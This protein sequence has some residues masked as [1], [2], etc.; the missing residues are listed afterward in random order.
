MLKLERLD[1]SGFKSFVDPVS[2]RFSGGITGIVGPNGCGK[3][4]LSDAISWVMGEQSAKSMRGDTME[5]VIF[6]GAEKRRPLGMGEVTLTF[7]APSGTSGVEDGRIILSRRVF[8]S[9]ESQYRLNGKLTRLKDVRDLLMDTGLGVRAYSVIEQGKIGMI[10]SGKPQER[11]RLLEEAAGITRYKERKRIA[12]IKIEEAAANLLRLDDILSEIERNLRSLKRQAG[13]A[14]R[15]RERQ[16]ELRDLERTVFRGRWASLAVALA[17][18]RDELAGTRAR[19]SELSATVHRAAAA[20]ARDREEIE[21]QAEALAV[22]VRRQAELAATIEGRQQLLVGARR[23]ST[24]IALRLDAGERQAQRLDEQLA[25]HQQSSAETAELSAR[26]V[27]DHQRAESAVAATAAELA[28]AEEQ[29]ERAESALEVLRRE[30]L[31]SLGQLDEL[32]LR[33]HREEIEG[34][35]GSFRERHLVDEL[36]AHA[37]ELVEN[38]RELAFAEGRLAELAELQALQ[39]VELAAAR[40]R[41]EALT[42]SETAAGEL[43]RQLESEWTTRSERRRLLADLA[44]SEADR[45]SAFAEQAAA[46]G[47]AN[48]PRLR[49]SVRAERGWEESL[50]P[51]VAPLVD[52]LVLP[53]DLR[54]AEVV[55]RWTESERAAGVLLSP[56]QPGDHL[57]PLRP[58]DPAIVAGLGEALGVESAIAEALPPAWLV[59]SPADAERLARAHPGVAFL[60]RRG[61]W[62]LGGLLH[63]AGSVAQPG[64]LTRSAELA[65]LA[66]ELPRLATELARARAELDSM[67]ANRRS[68]EAAIRPLEAELARRGQE[69]AVA[70]AE[71]E[72]LASRS[73]QLEEAELRLCSDHASVASELERL[74]AARDGLEREIARLTALHRQRESDLDRARG[75][76]EELR[77]ARETL[78]AVAAGRRGELELLAERVRAIES[79]AA[80]QNREHE[81]ARQQRA[82]WVDDALVLAVRRQELEAE[83]QLAE[84]ELFEALELRAGGEEP[85]VAERERLDLDRQ[86]LRT[87]ESELAATRERHLAARDAVEAVRIALAGLDHDAGH[88]AREIEERCGEAPPEPAELQPANLAELEDDLARLR[89]QLE[90][91]G[92]VNLLAAEEYATE[93]ERQLFLST[94]RADVA[95]SLESLRQTIREI[96][97]TSSA[98]FRETFTAVNEQFART[99]VELFRG[100]E[101]EMRLMDEEDLLDCGIEIVARPP[102]KRLQNLMLL[103]GGEKALTAIALLFALFRVKPSPF[104]ILDEVDAP[105]DDV[106][107]LRFV[108]MLRELARETQCIVITH[109]KLT[110]EVAA[111]LYGVTMEERGVS[112]L[113]EVELE[114]VQP[115]AATA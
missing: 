19:E 59:E 16:G 31:A 22:R 3:S 92:P 63:L 49:D 6:N 95:S 105:L 113:I 102:G 7:E 101:A 93:E 77:G 21:R 43:L 81:A 11:R 83:I 108:G 99:F 103:S 1:L 73:V 48:A 56:A 2:L 51:F 46:A 107:T 110:M 78:R 68:A 4:N 75:S 79:Q 17:A 34:E 52:A 112:K 44:A 32:R 71:R 82:S 115:Q 96:N 94:Q 87:A 69:I 55:A 100:G 98:R 90:A 10:L 72:R 35:K 18:R 88:L 89:L 23:T 111:T 29:T 42:R 8:R 70:G 62:A 106:N 40:S 25:A 28:G 9:G 47:I 85:L 37:S 33:L 27:D 97:Q 109:N 50:D 64:F 20:I 114:E 12:E 45:G 13:A 24:E 84:R 74:T 65:A 57:A 67:G 53:A 14:R 66:E 36:G 15:F 39:E 38:R 80:R 60:S 41:L 26:L 54:A 58:D 30:L 86:R 91:I 61:S 76:A 5:D 104:C